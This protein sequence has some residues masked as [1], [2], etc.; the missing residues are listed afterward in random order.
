M[1]REIALTMA[2]ANL[3]FA[4]LRGPAQVGT[5]TMQTQ[6][7]PAS[8]LIFSVCL[9]HI[10]RNLSVVYFGV[11]AATA[12]LAFIIFLQT[13]YH[14]KMRD[15][16]L[17]LVVGIYG[18]VALTS[19]YW[20]QDYGE[21]VTGLARLVFIAPALIGMIY[22][23]NAKSFP[24]YYTIWLGFGVLAALSLPAQFVLG[25]VSWFA[26]SSER[27]G[28][29]RFGSLAGSVTVFGN[30]VG[31]LI[32]IALI[33]KGNFLLSAAIT[34]IILVGAVASLQKAALGSA[35]I[36]LISAVLA[37]RARLSTVASLAVALVVALGLIFTLADYYARGIVLGYVQNILG[38]GD[39]S[40][41]S[42][43][44]FV[45]SMISRWT[46]FPEIAFHYFGFDSLFTGVG[47]FGGS[48]SL[49]YPEY[50]H[51]HNLIFET[52][53]VFGGIV[54]GFILA[55]LVYISWRSGLIVFGFGKRDHNELIAAGI[56]LNLLLPTIFAGAL[57]YHPVSGSMFVCS[58]LYLAFSLSKRAGA[59]ARAAPSARLVRG[60][61]EP[62]GGRHSALSTRAIT[63]TSQRL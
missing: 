23:L 49:G 31:A 48:G 57:F 6:L 10:T 40:R 46:H 43:V 56:F 41:A 51:T 36:G 25:S 13:P 24:A 2:R 60:G 63:R 35:L 53:L 50:P 30:L 27:A 19:L 38:T 7:L 62:Y 52:L 33:R 34:V 1:G 4:T 18:Y 17:A 55:G 5:T 59:T 15:I 22:T 37:S 44:T 61:D 8:L 28:T 9:L 26:E 58:L 16:A 3:K 45:E 42:D 20:S 54:G 14:Y 32:F 21:P 39:A 47:V 11:W 12:A 29:D